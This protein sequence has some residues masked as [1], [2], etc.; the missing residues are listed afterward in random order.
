MASKESIWNPWKRR[1]KTER[2]NSMFMS[3]ASS[4]SVPGTQGQNRN[5]TKQKQIGQP[6]FQGGLI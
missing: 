6:L 2:G 3:I 5:T 1:K 4:L